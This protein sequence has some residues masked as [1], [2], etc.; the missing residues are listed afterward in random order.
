MSVSNTKSS[1]QPFSPSEFKEI[2]SRVPRLCVDIVIKSNLGVLMTKRTLSSWKGLWHLP[3]G[4]VYY[5]ETAKDAVKRVAREEL[6]VDVGV[7][8][9]LGYIEYPSE[10]KER[11]FGWSVSLVFLCHIIEGTPSESEQGSKP[12]FYHSLPK[13]VVVEQKEFLENILY[14]STED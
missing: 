8:T 7:D 2:Y 11:G 9:F 1:S 6:G 10:E 14:V 5:K 12:T 13:E 3:G 4:T